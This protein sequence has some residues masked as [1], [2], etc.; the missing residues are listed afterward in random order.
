MPEPTVTDPTA[1]V[2][3]DHRRPVPRPPM[4]SASRTSPWL[5][6]LKPFKPYVYKGI[7]FD[8]FNPDEDPDA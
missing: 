1:V 4:P 3:R 6:D 5:P 2:D 7:G 8:I